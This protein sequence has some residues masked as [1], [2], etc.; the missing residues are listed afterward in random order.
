MSHRT[1]TFE[2]KLFQLRGRKR[3]ILEQE[4]KSAVLLPLIKEPDGQWHILFEVRSL[5][6]KRQPGEICF[7]GGRVDA[8]DHS[9]EQAAIRETCEELNLSSQNVEIICPLDIL[10]KAH[11]H[12]IYPFAG[13]IHDPE[14]IHPNPSEVEEVFT[15]PM[16]WLLHHEPELHLVDMVAKPHD[17]FPYHLI[18]NGKDYN[19]QKREIPEYF[20]LYQD[21][22]IWGMTARILYHFINLVKSTHTK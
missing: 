5:H 10:A 16:D 6:L 15:V 1:V 20:Y 21:W 17:H 9:E 3:S 8:S 11:R 19:W 12:T 4:L 18:P 22:V 2:E 14:A 7:P 13:I